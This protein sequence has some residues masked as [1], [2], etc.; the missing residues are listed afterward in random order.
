MA[1]SDSLL[2]NKLEGSDDYETQP[3]ISMSESG[4]DFTP[5]NY[6]DYST[7]GKSELADLDSSLVATPLLLGDVVC[8]HYLVRSIWCLHYLIL[9]LDFLDVYPEV[10]LCHSEKCDCYRVSPEVLQRKSYKKKKQIHETEVV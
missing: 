10:Y 7:S 4:D 3:D 1:L 8:L 9:H 6:S 5:E 2:A